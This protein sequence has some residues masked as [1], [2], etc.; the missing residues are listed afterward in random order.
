MTSVPMK[1][2]ALIFTGRERDSY[3]RSHLSYVEFSARP[4]RLSAASG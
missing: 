2:A 3:D 1:S 4:I